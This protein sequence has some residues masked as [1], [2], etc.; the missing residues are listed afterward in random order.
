MWRYI[1]QR[2]LWMI[3]I[4]IGVAFVIFTVMYFCPGDPA[5][6]ILG[7]EATEIELEEYRHYLGLDQPYI[8]QLGRYLYDT[9][10]RFDLGTSYTKKSAVALEVITRAPRTLALGWICILIDVVIGIPLGIACALNRNSIW[11]RLVMVVAMFGVSMPGFW[12]ALMLVL[13][14][15]SKLHWLPP[16]GI[17]TWKHWVMPIIAIF[18]GFI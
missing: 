18:T 15:T 6:L 5:E 11:D 2:L 4:M 3:F 7:S 17:G 10:I 1:G 8:V 12:V 9:F 16:Y 14:F 13:L